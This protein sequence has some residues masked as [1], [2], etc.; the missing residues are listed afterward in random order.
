M[1][2]VRGLASLGAALLALAALVTLA[3]CGASSSAPRESPQAD[4][5]PT[6]RH[7]ASAAGSGAVGGASVTAVERALSTHGAT[8]AT[9]RPSSPSERANA[10]FGHTRRPVF[11]CDLTVSRQR[12]SYVVQVLHNGC[13][14]AERRHRGRTL[15]GCGAGRS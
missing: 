5:R 2:S 8:S 11:T 9:C 1:S 7:A 14:V 12:A 13:F 3:G 4:T 6:V 10:P 15:Y